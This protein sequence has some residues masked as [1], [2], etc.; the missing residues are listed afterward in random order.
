M[1]QHI[2]A[3]VHHGLEQASE[4]ADAVLHII[5]GQYPLRD[6]VERRKWKKAH[7]HQHP[8][9]DDKADW[10]D[11]RFF[12]LVE[13]NRRRA[14]VEHA[15]IEDQPARRLDLAQRFLRWHAYLEMLLDK[16]PFFSRRVQQV[17]PDDFGRQFRPDALPTIGRPPVHREHASNS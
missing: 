12:V 9:S 11:L 17:D 13:T 8:R 5:V 4:Y 2:S 6:G 3:A 15:L 16:L 14:E 10:S 1:L 7:R